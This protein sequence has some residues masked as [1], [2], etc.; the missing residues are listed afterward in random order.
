M[1]NTAR[2]FV[3]FGLRHADPAPPRRSE[4]TRRR[5]STQ[6]PRPSS[7]S[8]ARLSSRAHRCI[9]V[10]HFNTC[11]LPMGGAIGCQPEL[12]VRYARQGTIRTVPHGRIY[13]K[14]LFLFCAG[15]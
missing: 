2:L 11:L 8:P 10:L 6:S 13:T 12:C 5:G 14:T 3:A 4:A 9:R 15:G 1:R 7:L